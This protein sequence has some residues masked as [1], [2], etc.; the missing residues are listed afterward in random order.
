[1]KEKL[2]IAAFFCCLLT[3]Q[4]IA[5]PVTK[6]S[7]RSIAST[8][9][10]SLDGSALSET[11]VTTNAPKRIS[12][13]D[14]LAPYY[15][16]SRGEDKGFVIVSGD[17]CVPSIIGY[18]EKGNFDAT[19][20]PEA[21]KSMLEGWS[22]LV[23][24]AQAAGAK[25]R[26]LTNSANKIRK[27][28]SERRDIGPLIKTLWGQGSPY[29]DLCPTIKSSGAHAL[30]G[31][32]ATATSQIVYYFH[33][34]NPDTLLY[35]T[36][37]YSYGDA[38]VTTSLPS[39]TKIDY[40]NMLLSGS[41]TS[42]QNNA[43]ATLMVAVGTSSYL[44][45]GSS[46]SGQISNAGN[47][48]NGQFRLSSTCIYKSGYSQSAWEDIVYTSLSAG[49]PILYCGVHP[50]NGG[51]AVVLD[52]YQCSTNKFHFNFGW[53]NESYNGYFT[54]D[55]S[56][57]MNGFY[58]QQ[59]MCYNVTPKIQNIAG[60]IL[61]VKNFY[62]KC[63]NT[64]SVRIKNN[65]TIDY[66]GVYLY[67]T[68]AT[69]LPTSE[70]AKD[71]T[72]TIATG[73]STIISF[74]YKPTLQKIY[75]IFLCNSNRT[76]LDSCSVVAQPTTA[77]LHLNKMSIDAGNISQDIDGITF[78]TVNNTTA[79]VK[80]NLTNGEGGSYCQPTLL[81][82]LYQY[83]TTTKTWGTETASSRYLTSITFHENE[84]KDTIFRFS[85][86]TPGL[87]YKAIMNHTATAGAKSNIAFDT[88]DSIVFFTVKEP[89]MA[90]TRTGR[91][92]TVTG[93]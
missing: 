38:P 56:T 63:N 51:H 23:T 39:G 49:K 74:T 36:P 7:A 78:K 24:K 37:T 67:C 4:T 72:T 21:F 79:D 22:E 75:H 11:D 71:I 92:A 41:G 88:A 48:M 53:N 5:D 90:I 33:K 2:T 60:K 8:F 64:L 59:G 44:T 87:Y 16:F 17:D 14:T 91:N 50:T 68:T 25:S 32:V 85:G 35:S 19:N 82:E 54:V 93:T 77:A 69:S 3:I 58:G 62:Q 10:S 81:C 15:I 65:S 80:V 84:T 66:S 57:G 52:G 27:A 61:E 26:S 43:V 70:N 1:M 31:C 76:I 29:N 18:T 6:N 42:V 89:N 9:L 55:D 20:M 40:A 12:A 30:T 34:D 86:L 47:A 73:D 45:Y 83:D 13:A 46:T 28:T